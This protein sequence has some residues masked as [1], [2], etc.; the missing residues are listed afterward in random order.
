VANERRRLIATVLAVV[1]LAGVLVVSLRLGESQD[2]RERLEVTAEA[3]AGSVDRELE[4]FAEL[5]AAVNAAVALLPEVDNASYQAL[6]EEF[7]IPERYPSLLAVNRAVPVPRAE[8]PDLIASEQVTDPDFQVRGD[9]GEDELRLVLQVFPD[10]ADNAVVRGF[11]IVGRPDAYDANERA[12][13][14]GEPALSHI[15]E[16]VQL[17]AS[18]RGAVLYDPHVGADGQV[19]WWI[20][21]LFSGESFLRQLEPLPAPVA[22]RIVDPHEDSGAVLGE[23]GSAPDGPG[24]RATV[25]RFGEVWELEVR[26][27]VGFGTPWWRR[28]STLAGVGGLIVGGLLVVLVHSLS[29][30]ERR[31]QELAEQRTHE[32][33]DANDELAAL[34]VALREAN[35]D[36]DAFLAAVS[37][38]LRTPLTVIGGFSDSLRRMRDDPELVLFLDPIDRNVR[39]LDGLVSDLLTLASLDAGAV[40]LFPE[41]VD[42]AELALEA[43]RELAGVDDQHVRIDAPEPVVVRADRRH[44]ERILINLLTNAVRHGGPPVDVHV[45]RRDDEGVVVVR[46]HGNG[47]DPSLLPELFGRFVRGARTEQVSGTGLGLAIVRELT[48]LNRGRVAYHDAEPGAC[49]EVGLPLARTERVGRA[50]P[51]MGATVPVGELG[52]GPDARRGSR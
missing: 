19:D 14:A 49:F 8:L 15:T 52:A 39:R 4:R 20:G 48:E 32:L 40:E 23:I 36:K 13:L 21:L 6:L 24:Q 10:E 17:P 5:G 43:P 45:R 34:N 28:G 44:A 7:D 51:P 37:H 38:E 41:E 29:T 25:E 27:G 18:E 16:L 12:R 26:P 47:L 50:Q 2:E 35:A 22:V 3:L 42:L 46:D 30:R 1:V 31:A 11:D 33:A 9:A